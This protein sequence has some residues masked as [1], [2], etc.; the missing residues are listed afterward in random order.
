MQ[1]KLKKMKIIVIFLCLPLFLV[2]AFN[3]CA[4]SSK[5]STDSG[6]SNENLESPD[7]SKLTPTCFA[8][9]PSNPVLTGGS[10]F[11]GSTWNDPSVINVGNQYVMYASSDHNFDGNIEIYR[12]V[13]SNGLA[14]S[15]SPSAPVFSHSSDV[16]AWD[17]KSVETPSVVYFNGK[18]HLFYTGYPSTH[19]DSTSYKIG[20]ATSDDGITWVRDASYIL[21]PTN[22]AGAPNLDFNQYIVAEP[23]AVVF[24]NKIYLYFTALG[25]NVDVGTTLQVIGLT[26]SADGIAWTTPQS[27]LTP[28]QT[29]YPRSTW[30]GYSTPSAIVLDGKIHLFFDVVQETP[31]K[32]LRIHH[33]SSSNGVSGW[34]QDSASI[35]SQA[36]FGWSSNEIRSPTALLSGASLALWLSGDNGSVLSIGQASC[37]LK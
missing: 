8:S 21:A 2:F 6:A 17:F 18:Y 30:L 23:A 28:D 24:N 15:L 26:T 31:W 35:F 33:A 29:L 13:S 3:N 19:T 25:A 36:S 4:P 32:Q 27:V 9:S 1:V 20:H 5:S 7:Y 16:S 10:L 11:S 34:T 37:S 12:L 14:W 22:P